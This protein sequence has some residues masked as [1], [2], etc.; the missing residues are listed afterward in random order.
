MNTNKI[1]KKIEQYLKALKHLYIKERIEK[2]KNHS[3]SLQDVQEQIK[4]YNK[5]LEKLYKQK[6]KNLPSYFFPK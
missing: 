5:E 2:K 6:I 4:L 3:N 1:E